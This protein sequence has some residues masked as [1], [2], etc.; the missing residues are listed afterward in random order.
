MI[1]WI[2][3]KSGAGK[4]TLAYVLKKNI[5]RS[6]ILDGDEIRSIIPNDFSDEGRWNNITTVIKLAELLVKQE[7]VPIVAMISPKKEWREEARKHF[8]EFK[9][10]YVKGGSL[11]KGTTYDEPTEDE[12]LMVYDWKET[13]ECTKFIGLLLGLI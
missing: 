12:Y 2:T 8:E 11:W 6:I 1:Y 13:Y 9:L 7:Y 5:R 10:I 3:G 4:T